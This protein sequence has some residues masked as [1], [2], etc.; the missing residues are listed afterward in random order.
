MF[1][2]LIEELG[3]LRAVQAIPNGRVLDIACRA[4]LE[5]MAVGDSLA[6]NGACQTVVGVYADGV[7][8]EAV[9]DTLA[10]TTLGRL[11]AGKRLNLERACRADG[12]LG[13]HF[14]LGHVQ[15]VAAVLA[16]RPQGSGWRLE[17]ALPPELRPYLAAEGSIAVDGISLTVAGLEADRF[18]VSVIP[19]SARATTL[20]DI[21]PGDPVNL[22]TDILARYVEAQVQARRPGLGEDDLRRWGYRA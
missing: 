1:T 21:R 7:R 5:G 4:V 8:V 3:S 14:V 11:A 12:R 10:K 17:V 15:A 20:A 9:G 22:E 18:R 6:V 19:H 16:W 13:G 2:G